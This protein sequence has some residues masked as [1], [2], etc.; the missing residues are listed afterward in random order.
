MIAIYAVLATLVVAI[1]GTG[2]YWAWAAHQRYKYNLQI[3]TDL[4][5]LMKEAINLIKKYRK[6]SHQQIKP[7]L[8]DFTQEKTKSDSIDSPALLSTIL[9]VLVKK[10]GN[11]RLSVRDFMIP[12][13][14]YV[15][16]YIDTVTRELLLSVND[17][18]DETNSYSMVNFTDPDDNTF[19]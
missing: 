7:S 17:S 16:V 15:S 14:E 19:H 6:F 13:E 4:N 8:S 12:D 10:F 1:I 18:V 5:R 2:S 9:T 3:S 11:V